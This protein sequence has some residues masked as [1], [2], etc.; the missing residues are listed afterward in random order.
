[1]TRLRTVAFILIL[2]GA[3]SAA[4][5]LQI[6]TAGDARWVTGGVGMDERTEMTQ[7]LPGYNLK[8]LAAEKVSGAFLA[9]V[10]VTVSAANKTVI[11]TALDGP[12]LLTRLAPGRYEV[13][14]TFEGN[15]QTRTVSVPTTG[16]AEAAFYWH[17]PGADTL[18]RSRAQ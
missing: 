3:S 17:V 5:A 15:T 1:M 14:A 2:A 16:R 11:D 9:N 13:R 8:V 18:P 12:W 6:Q 7:A 10:Q 4:N